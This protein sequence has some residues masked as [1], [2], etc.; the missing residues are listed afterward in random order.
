MIGISTFEQEFYSG[1]NIQFRYRKK[2]DGTFMPVTFR[3]CSFSNKRRLILKIAQ[4]KIF[5]HNSLSLNLIFYLFR[6]TQL[7]KQYI[8]YTFI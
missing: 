7:E 5:L 2:K 1:T 8:I 6:T 4:T 3:R